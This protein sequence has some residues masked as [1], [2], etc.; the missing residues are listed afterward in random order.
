[1]IPD[2]GFE[3]I[4]Q[5]ASP[6]DFAATTHAIEAA[7]GMKQQ[8]QSSIVSADRKDLKISATR[9]GKMS[10]WNMEKFLDETKNENL[11]ERRFKGKAWKISFALT[12]RWRYGK[13]GTLAFL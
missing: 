7:G 11:K 1:M 9:L 12:N 13:W 2:S 5:N 10:T 8:Y 3:N 6:Y 4:S